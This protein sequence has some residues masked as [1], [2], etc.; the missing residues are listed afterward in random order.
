MYCN[1]LNLH[2]EFFWL[3]FSSVGVGSALAAMVRATLNRMRGKARNRRS[4]D[5]WR[6]PIVHAALSLTLAFTAVSGALFFIDPSRISWSLF[7]LYFY[8][9]V[10]GVALVVCLFLRYLA[11]PL[12]LVV[13]AYVFLVTSLC[14]EWV[15]AVPGAALAE[16]RV[17]A[18][19]EGSVSLELTVETERGSPVHD[20]YKIEG[21]E[22]GYLIRTIEFPPWS[23]YPGTRTLFRPTEVHPTAAAP[24]GEGSPEIPSSSGDSLFSTLPAVVRAAEGLGI[25]SSRDHVVVQSEVMV[26]KNYGLYRRQASGDFFISPIEGNSLR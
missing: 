24:L 7:H 8:L 23:F 12:V 9:T 2:S 1:E 17:L 21:K 5:S 22:V 3:F 11:V 4:S 10:V 25:L 15:P 26:L 18:R 14:S 19:T 20:F 13:L 6:S 16:I